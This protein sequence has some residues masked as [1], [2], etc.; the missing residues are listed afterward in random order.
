MSERFI[1]DFKLMQYTKKA[2]RTA[3]SEFSSAQTTISVPKS[4]LIKK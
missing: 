2:M 1:S 4:V 3:F